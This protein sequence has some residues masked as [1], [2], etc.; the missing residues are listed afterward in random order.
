MTL[1]ATPVVHLEQLISYR[2][3]NVDYLQDAN[4]T[5]C[6]L[7]LLSNSTRQS[8]ERHAPEHFSLQLEFHHPCLNRRP[9]LP[10]VAATYPGRITYVEFINSVSVREVS[11]F[12]AFMA[13]IIAIPARFEAV[14]TRGFLQALI[15]CGATQVQGLLN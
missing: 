10:K 1:A 7:P 3:S 8:V 4:S 5:T 2:N 13:C 9:G 11:L 14:V 12:R 15:F 6:E